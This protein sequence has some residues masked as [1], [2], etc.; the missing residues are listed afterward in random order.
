MLQELVSAPATRCMGSE[1]DRFQRLLVV[2]R[3]DGLD[4]N[5]AMVRSGY[6]VAYGDYS[7]EETDA[8]AQKTGLWAGTFEMPRAVRDHARE[9]PALPG[10]LGLFGW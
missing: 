7:Q 5:G 3:A 10:A 4:V 2:C 6:A 8:R 1:R 9:T